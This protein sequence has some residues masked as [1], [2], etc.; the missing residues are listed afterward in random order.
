MTKC[1]VSVSVTFILLLLNALIWLALGVLLAI[2]AH[3]AIPDVP[4]IRW[5]M[6]FLAFA[7][8]GI[9]LGLLVLLGKRYPPAYYIV[10]GI[11]AAITVLT[12]FDQV[13]LIDLLYLAINLA[14]IPMLI[15]DRAWYLQ[16]S[17]REAGSK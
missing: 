15:K 4:L 11:L 9:L 1:P 8:G 3:P 5:G 6:T 13:G 17:A 12:F 16:R 10:I 2:N 14:P 7:G